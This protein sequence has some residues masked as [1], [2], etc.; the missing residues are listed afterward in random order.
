MVVWW[1]SR[2]KATVVAVVTG[3]YGAEGNRQVTA[4]V[5]GSKA[6]IIIVVI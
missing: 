2:G 5:G 1:W 4:G 6:G 3:G